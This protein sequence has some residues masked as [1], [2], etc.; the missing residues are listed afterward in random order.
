MGNAGDL[1]YLP[2]PPAAG[3]FAWR[4]LGRACPH[5]GNLIRPSSS[6]A[7]KTLC[8][9]IR[10]MEPTGRNIVI[11]CDGTGNEFGTDNSNIVK[12]FHVLVRDS[13]QLAFY[14]PGLGTMA[15]PRSQTKP[16][17]ILTK[18]LGLAFGY[19]LQRNI[20]DAYEY[21]VEHYQP[22]D[23][24]YLFGFSRGAYT[25]RALAGMLHKVGLHDEGNLNQVSYAYRMFKNPRNAK[26]AAQ[27][28][29]TFCRTVPIRFLGVF[30]TVSS[31]GRAWSPKSLPFT[32]S[33]PSVAIVRHAV[34]LDERRAK[35]RQNLWDPTHH[36]H[37]EVWFAGVH[38]DIGGGYPES[39]SDLAHI[40][41]DWMIAQA[42]S[43]GLRIDPEK[44]QAIAGRRSQGLAAP[45]PL[46]DAHESLALWWWPLEFLPFPSWNPVTRSKSLR[47]NLGRR[48]FVHPDA[49]LHHTVVERIQKRADYKPSN[50]P[51]KYTVEPPSSENP[52][53]G[54]DSNN[55]FTQSASS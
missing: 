27:Y 15:S 22:G 5:F 24:V 45:N 37:R 43:S 52:A 51:Q 14:D 21:L 41:L 7:P 33:N 16:A 11:C 13:R 39:E 25:V 12:L 4:N 35:F 9:M 1:R 6:L 34:A 36:D 2:L 29:A 46:A 47:F 32:R 26:V 44:Y 20:E 42:R 38:S 8:E 19:G 31:V 23:N 54:P 10:R 3:Y 40:A 17:K 50:L 48:R 49:V 28:R 55:G 30:D 18:M 53:N